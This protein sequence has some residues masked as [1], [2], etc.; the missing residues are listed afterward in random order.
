MCAITAD[1]VKRSA[2]AHLASRQQRPIEEATTP[3]ARRAEAY[4][5]GTS[6]RSGRAETEAIPFF[7]RAI[8]LDRR[9]ALPNDAV[10]P[11]RGPG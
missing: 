11:V 5:E 8:A 7:E 10:E 4:A 6:R 9:F 1:C 3:V 2:N